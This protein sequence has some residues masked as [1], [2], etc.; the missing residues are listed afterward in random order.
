MRYRKLIV[1]SG[2]FALL[3][4]SFHV[5]CIF[6]GS[7]LKSSIA[8]IQQKSGIVLGSMLFDRA[9]NNA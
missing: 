6:S 3:L 5:L 2:L 4:L 9:A 1:F 7:S 8:F